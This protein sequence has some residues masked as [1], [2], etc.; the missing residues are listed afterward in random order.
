MVSTYLSLN[1]DDK[2]VAK[3]WCFLAS[4][5]LMECYPAGLSLLDTNGPKEFSIDH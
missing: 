2:S 5:V 4:T 3:S 1:Y